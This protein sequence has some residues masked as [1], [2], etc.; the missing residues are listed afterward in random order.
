ME[1]RTLEDKVALVTGAGR[2]I[3]RAI[4][5][6]LSRAGAKVAVNVRVSRKEG[7]A[8]V[9]EIAA[10]GG[11][12]WLFAADITRRVEVDCMVKGISERWGRLDILVNNAAIRQE[13]AFADIGY[14]EWRSTLDV[15]VDGAFH[16]TQA[17][18]PWLCASP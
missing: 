1:T 4:A 7:Q 10:G 12:A 14:A 16:C 5:L 9:A 3:G 18:L 17:A 15:C 6:A 11:E 13:A 8:V 2:N